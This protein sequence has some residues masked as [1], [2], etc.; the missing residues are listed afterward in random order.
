VQFL[1]DRVYVLQGHMPEATELFEKLL[2]ISNDLTQLSEEYDSKHGLIGN[3]PQAF[4][5]IGL[6]NAALGLHLGVP[7]RLHD[8]K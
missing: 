2:A 6:I 4:S 5:H 3:F 8:L 7:V 1:A